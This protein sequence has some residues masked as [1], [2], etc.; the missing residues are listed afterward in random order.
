MTTE[1]ETTFQ[2][3]PADPVKR[4]T[5]KD[6]AKEALQHKQDKELAKTREDKVYGTIKDCSD[7]LEITLDTFKSIVNHAYEEAKKNKTLNKLTV[8][9]EGA[10]ILG[11]V[12]SD[13]FDY[14]SEF[15]EE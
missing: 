1:Y 8:G 10:E 12:E 14:S 9:K 3:L 15:D 4:A 2:G 11:L 5:I 13:E 7:N 6:Y